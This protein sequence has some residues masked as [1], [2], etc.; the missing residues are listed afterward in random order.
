MSELILFMS[1]FKANKKLL[2]R[3][4]RDKKEIYY[5]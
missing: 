1:L 2:P 5:L 3:I 4:F